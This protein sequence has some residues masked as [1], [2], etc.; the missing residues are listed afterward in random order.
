MQ[1]HES[2]C[3]RTVENALTEIPE[4]LRESVTRYWESFAT[5]GG[6][7]QLPQ[8]S[9]EWLQSLPR[10][11]A[12]SDFATQICTRTPDVLA[13]LVTSGDLL[14]AYGR[15]VV[16]TYVQKDLEQCTDELT[17]ALSLRRRRQR[18]MLRLAW[19]DLAGWAS[20][21]EIVTTL[22]EY[23]D[24]CIDNAL[25]HIYRWTCESW[26]TPIGSESG[27]PQQ[28]VVLGLGKLGGKEL[29]FSSDI[30][31]IFTYPEEGETDGRRT[32]SNHEFFL[33]VGQRL[34]Q[35]LDNVDAN[36]FVF[37]TDLRLRPNGDS[38][39][40][41]LPFSAMEHYYQTHGR[42]WERYALIKA[43]VV[44]GDKRQGD[45]LLRSLRPFVYRKYLDYGAFKAI[46]EMKLLIDRELERKG[47]AQ[48]VKL[49]RGGI[50]EIE[51]IAQ[52]FQLIHGGREPGLQTPH[53]F[54]ALDHLGEIGVLEDMD[55]SQLKKNYVFL[56]K[57]EHCLQML[58][59]QQTHQLPNEEFAQ[60]RLAYAMHYGDWTAFEKRL[61][62]VRDQVQQSF[63]Q[64]FRIQGDTKESTSDSAFSDIWM[65]TKSSSEAAVFLRE[66][67]FEAPDKIL[68]LLERLRSGA[69]YRTFSTEGRDRLDALMP[70]LI[71]SAAQNDQPDLAFK[72]L[73]HVIESIGRRATYFSLL[74]ENPLAR[75]Q[76]VKLCAASGW[77]SQWMAQHPIVLDELI[78]PISNFQDLNRQQLKSDL[79][80]RL[81]AISADDLETAMEVL[82]DFRH[83][84]A[85]RIA[86]ADVADILPPG[87]VSGQLCLI[88]ET[89]LDQSLY[90]A[91]RSLQQRY[92][93]VM[94]TVGTSGNFSQREI[95]FT[96]VAYGK[97]GSGELGYHSDLDIVFIYD[98]IEDGDGN[99]VGG[100][101]SIPNTHY[102]GRL[103]QRLVH[104]L[105]TRTSGGILYETDTRLR[106]S[107]R[108]GTMVTSINAFA[109]YQKNQAW[110][111]E[112][113]AL[114]RAR[115]VVG[116]ERLV[117]EFERIRCEVL[118][119]KRD[120]P[121]LTQDVV[122]MREKMI[123]NNSQSTEELFDLKLERGGLVDIEFIVQYLVLAF[124]H[125]YPEL[126]VSRY[127]I[128]LLETAAELTLLTDGQ[129]KSLADA[130]TR[131]LTKEHELK[132]A[133]Q[134]SVV[135][136]DQVA[137]VSTTVGAIW[138]ELFA[139]HL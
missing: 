42:D 24:A 115:M 15:D 112:H 59:D 111:W 81:A 36:G 133:E 19:R 139:D 87:K 34:V 116:S 29:N 67:G 126:T 26:G 97:L 16:S 99:T 86:A 75:M 4:V 117:N 54:T 41:V 113:Q 64:T 90:V 57:V 38:G 53:L 84:H 95:E 13:E 131:Y 12:C 66:S 83:T 122:D 73:L 9:Y 56:R 118:R 82:R 49:G 85:L 108:S 8:E 79:H 45:T 104:I 124:A 102:F 70:L 110:T 27:E 62:G 92:G 138:D 129:A 103:G 58:A 55:I 107:G 132:L 88:A 100:E 128:D 44:G 51:F 43:R 119:L 89:A 40:L 28:L 60:I 78:D 101:Q 71:E 52:S 33:R 1:D 137:D 98:N 80:R 76:L 121:K 14:K 21:D 94:H 69:S 39:A 7:E 93:N 22:S 125:R 65:Q 105:T 96:I 10:V 130:Y 48:N 63:D 18:E 109:D 72:R 61:H 23:A 17:L 11:W 134:A 91:R 37:R 47:I 68:D 30:D 6:I 20:V 127:T 2:I 106:P 114:V 5:T 50:R 120:P 35:A 3:R 31:L 123:A 74:I 77:I 32:R 46:R 136:R 135:P 25:A